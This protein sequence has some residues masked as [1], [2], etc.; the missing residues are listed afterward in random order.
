MSES[1]SAKEDYAGLRRHAENIL[2]ETNGKKAELTEHGL[3]ELLHELE[4]HQVELDLQNEELQRA[5][6]DLEA[7]HD[8]YFKFYEFAPVGFFTLD[9]NGTIERAN[10]AAADLLQGPR[11]YLA[12]QKFSN[13]VYPED[14]PAYFAGIKKVSESSVKDAKDSLELR[15]TGKDDHIIYA[16]LE[17]G[18]GFDEQGRFSRWQFAIADITRQKQDQEALHNAHDLL[19]ARVKE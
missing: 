15:L 16:R 14:L 1:R 13:R 11:R 3:L 9:R 7:A 8:E 12:G 5:A 2:K 6:K 18:A 10:A 17:L 4:V 19:E